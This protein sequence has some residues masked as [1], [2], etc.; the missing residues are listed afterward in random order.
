MII[1]KS[2]VKLNVIVCLVWSVVLNLVVVCLN[3]G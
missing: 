1:V 3:F 2:Y